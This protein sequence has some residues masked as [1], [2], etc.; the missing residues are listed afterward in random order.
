[1]FVVA[2]DA[3]WVAGIEA[4]AEEGVEFGRIAAEGRLRRGDIADGDGYLGAFWDI[5]GVGEADDAVSVD[6]YV[7]VHCRYSIRTQL[8]T[9]V[10]SDY[11]LHQRP[12][13]RRSLLGHLGRRCTHFYSPSNVPH[14][15]MLNP[16]NRPSDNG[17]DSSTYLL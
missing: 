2:G 15:R 14:L 6:A 8:T 13:P 3:E 4:F 7:G 17:M 11:D 5:D 9:V 1:M 10:L 12:T 16:Q